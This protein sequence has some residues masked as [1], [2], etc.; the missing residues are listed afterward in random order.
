[1]ASIAA[2]H[3][4]YGS[5]YISREHLKQSICQRY[6]AYFTTLVAIIHIIT[7]GLWL[8]RESLNDSLCSTALLKGPIYSTELLQQYLFEEYCVKCMKVPAAS[9]PFVG[10]F[11]NL[12]FHNNNCSYPLNI[13]S[14]L[15]EQL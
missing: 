15:E 3:Y 1:M 4:F 6:C 12:Q 10:E 5:V 8:I 14:F 11:V 9:P 7:S 2:T 13:V